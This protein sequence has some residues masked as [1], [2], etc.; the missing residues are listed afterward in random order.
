MAAPD[1]R[2]DP[3]D[4]DGRTAIV[5]GA[6]S[7]LGVTYAEALGA[8]GMNVVL[9]ARRTERLEAVAESIAADGGSALPVTCDVGDPDQVAA[10]A[11]AACER[12]GR[13]DLLVNNAGTTA[14]AGPMPERLPHELFEQTIRVNLLG[15]WYGCREVGARMLAQGSGSIINI[16]SVA[17]LAGLQA[18]PPA[19]QASKAAV[20]NLTRNLALSWADRGVRVNCLA[21]GW[22]PSEMASSLIE[23]PIY[24]DRIRSQ[25][26]VGRVGDPRELVGPLLFLASD[27]SSYV[28]GHTLV[29]DGGLSAS[30][31]HARYGPELYGFHAATVPDGLGEPIMPAGG[32]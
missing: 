30:L 18:F 19:Y 3:L 21:P 12:F 20:I 2:P 26:P 24:G 10:L 5:T 27:A 28:T 6:S 17:G 14:D 16:S 8:A 13:I 9:A 11:A 23:A 25:L 15:L 7:G 4:L 31:G 1:P 22:F 29:V 32:A